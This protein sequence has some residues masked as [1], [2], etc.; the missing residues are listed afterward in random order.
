M[1]LKINIKIPLYITYLSDSYSVFERQGMWLFKHIFMIFSWTASIYYVHRSVEISLSLFHL[2]FTQGRAH[3]HFVH[4][5]YHKHL[6][7]CW[8][9][10]GVS[11]AIANP[12]LKLIRGVSVENSLHEEL[13]GISLTSVV[14]DID[15]LEYKNCQWVLGSVCHHED[16]VGRMDWKISN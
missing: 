12:S 1:P 5:F 9:E 10:R 2:V 14:F 8:Q 7:T 6:T 4:Y 13:T 3:L 15:L 11:K 16:W